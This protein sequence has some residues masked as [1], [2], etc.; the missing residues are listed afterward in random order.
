MLGFRYKQRK[1]DKMFTLH[2]LTETAKATHY[3]A[4]MFNDVELAASRRTFLKAIEPAGS[5]NDYELAS[6][7]ADPLH[8]FRLAAVR[9]AA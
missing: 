6:G 3:R 9:A 2:I 1:G 4:E 5:S 7:E 8:R